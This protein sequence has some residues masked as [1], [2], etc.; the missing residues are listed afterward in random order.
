M[1][2]RVHMF[3]GHVIDFDEVKDYT[4]EGGQVLF[5]FRNGDEITLNFRSEEELRQIMG[6]LPS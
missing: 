1:N 2:E 5:R 4:R 6:C 3:D